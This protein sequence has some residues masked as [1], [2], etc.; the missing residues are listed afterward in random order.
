MT[1]D[2]KNRQGL[3]Q[4]D[5][6]F[7]DIID[8]YGWHV[9]KVVPNA[10]E[11]GDVFAYT[12]GLFFSF[13][14][15]EIIIFGLSL[16]TQHAILNQIGEQIRAGATFVPERF[17]FDIFANEVKCQFR[18]VQKRH[19]YA[20]VGWA[21]WFYEGDDFP[22]LQCFWPDNRGFFPWEEGCH[23]EIAKLQ[24]QLFLPDPKSLSS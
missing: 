3:S 2:P 23:P 1:R 4:Q 11:T 9:T 10:G 17:Y 14:Q 6:K 16:K 8:T 18:S 20:Y 21:R 19:Y 7:L 13:H 15:P 22:L 12:I 5:A 24:P